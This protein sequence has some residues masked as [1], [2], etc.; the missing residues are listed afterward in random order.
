MPPP[1][2]KRA[3]QAKPTSDGEERPSSDADEELSGSDGDNDNSVECSSSNEEDAS[4][5]VPTFTS[6]S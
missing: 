5:E 1:S 3:K 2:A 6:A 4:Q